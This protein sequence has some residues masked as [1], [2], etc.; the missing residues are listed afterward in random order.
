MIPRASALAAMLVRM[1]TRA[2]TWGMDTDRRKA[3]RAEIESDLWEAEHDLTADATRWPSLQIAA[4]LAAGAPADL[5]WRLEQS[6][7]G[8]KPMGRRIAAVII[9]VL[10]LLAAYVLVL[11]PSL[12]SPDL[13]PAPRYALKSD[14]PAGPPPPPPPHPTWEQFVRKVTT[15]GATND[16]RPNR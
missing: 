6:R 2:Y 3:R 10:S 12:E 11:P 13:P 9:T 15:Y 14:R 16:A 8:G 5:L 4:R 7:Q 1:W